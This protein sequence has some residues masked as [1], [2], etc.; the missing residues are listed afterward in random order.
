MYFQ[1]GK[2]HPQVTPMD[3]TVWN[4]RQGISNIIKIFNTGTKLSF[5]VK[6]Y[7]MR[8]FPQ[9]NNVD[10][11]RNNMSNIK[12]NCEMNTSDDNDNLDFKKSW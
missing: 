1:E 10:R 5:E 8:N 2:L 12:E 3:T 11:I 4:R 9:S 6:I 7:L